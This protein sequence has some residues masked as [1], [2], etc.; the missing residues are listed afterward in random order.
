MSAFEDGYA[1]AIDDAIH[2]LRHVDTL[3]KVGGTWLISKFD[4]V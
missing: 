1:K 3:D 2:L 4:P